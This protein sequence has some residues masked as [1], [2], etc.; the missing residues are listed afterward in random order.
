[1][2]REVGNHQGVDLFGDLVGGV[3]AHTGERGER[4]GSCDEL[5]GA[6]GRNAADRV[7]GVAPNQKR[8]HT[9][10]TDRRMPRASGTVPANRGRHRRTVADN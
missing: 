1:M 9:R 8:R 7:I 2:P 6:F 3:M 4:V 10:R 5:G